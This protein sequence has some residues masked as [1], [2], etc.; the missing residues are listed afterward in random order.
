MKNAIR[1]FMKSD[2]VAFFFALIL[3]TITSSVTLADVIPSDESQEPVSKKNVELPESSPSSPPMATDDPG[4]P[5]HLGVEI[6]FISNFDFFKDG[7][8]IAGGVDAN[9]GL[10][11]RWQLRVEKEAR[12]EALADGAYFFGAGSTNAGV[13]YRFYDDGNLKLAFYPSFNFDDAALRD[14]AEKE[15]RSF[16]FPIIVSKTLGRFTFIL[17]AGITKNIDIPETK[18][19]FVSFATGYAA[20]E[21]FRLMAEF[22]SQRVGDY[23]RN[24]IRIGGVHEIFPNEK[25]N[26]ETGVFGSIG[27]SV[28]DTEDGKTHTTVLVGFAFAKKPVDAEPEAPEVIKPQLIKPKVRR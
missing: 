17:N 25:S 12:R 2:M 3:T 4:T 13:K 14:G 6:N 20:D 27:R 19:N 23:R 16:Y 10:G 22:A 26:Y 1:R 5:G 28:G 11:D 8:E 15:G 21:A 18:Q 24:D 7:G 9:L